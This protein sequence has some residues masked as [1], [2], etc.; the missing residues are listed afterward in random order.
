MHWRLA[1]A[2]TRELRE[3]MELFLFRGGYGG[4]SLVEGEIANLCFVVKRATL[5][6]LGGYREV[7]KA[8]LSETQALGHRL[9]DAE[10]LWERPLAISPVP[11]GHLNESNNGLWRIGDQFAVIPSFTGDGMAIALHSGALASKMILRGEP[12]DAF[13]ARLGR[14]LRPGMNIALLLSRAMV[15]AAGR[16]LA[17]PA[18]AARPRAMQW[19]AERTRV[20]QSAMLGV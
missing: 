2:Q 17:V 7:L 14:Q 8:I 19:I 1:P 6:K 10:A 13:N 12:A 4:I 18:M 5:Q 15:S 11:Y 9:A 16:A 20:P 3:W